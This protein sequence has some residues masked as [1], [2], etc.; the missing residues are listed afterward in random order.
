MGGKP[1]KGIAEAAASGHE[2]RIMNLTAAIPLSPRRK[3]TN[4]PEIHSPDEP[5]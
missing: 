4:G 3:T 2:V 1:Q 5:N